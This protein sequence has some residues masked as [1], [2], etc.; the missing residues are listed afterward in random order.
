MIFYEA[1]WALGTGQTPEPEEVQAVHHDIRAFVKKHHGKDASDKVRIIYGGM[2]SLRVHF[3]SLE[4]CF[5][6]IEIHIIS[7]EV[8]F[9]FTRSTLHFYK[10]YVYT[11]HTS[12]GHILL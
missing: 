4:V 9:T 7:L 10:K 1:V 2:S 12:N 11:L 8:H 5:I 6:S 3:T